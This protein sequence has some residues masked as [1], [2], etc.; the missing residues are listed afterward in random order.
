M[1]Q[2]KWNGIKYMETMYD[3]FDAIPLI[4]LQPLPRDPNYGATNLLCYRHKHMCLN[5]IIGYAQPTKHSLLVKFSV[6]RF[7]ICFIFRYNNLEL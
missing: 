2:R 3:V 4:P 5:T 6:V 7:I 1:E